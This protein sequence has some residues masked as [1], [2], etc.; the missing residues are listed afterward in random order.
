MRACPTIPFSTL[1]ADTI[2]EHG[3]GFA[4]RY[5]IQRLRMPRWEVDFFFGLPA[6]GAAML[7][8]NGLERAQANRA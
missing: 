6:I 7:A 2:L 1:L 3:T 8:R 4:W 5:C